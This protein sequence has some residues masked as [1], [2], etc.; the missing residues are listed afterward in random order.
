MEKPVLERQLA[1]MTMF[2][3]TFRGAARPKTL[4]SLPF[5]QDG[6]HAR[7]FISR[8]LNA[9]SLFAKRRRHQR[10][11]ARKRLRVLWPTSL[12]PRAVGRKGREPFEQRFGFTAPEAAALL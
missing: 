3:A 2:R 5:G 4:A 8:S 11:T 7:A 6:D 9:D 10:E 12:S 1:D